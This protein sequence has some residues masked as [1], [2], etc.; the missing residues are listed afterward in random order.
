[1]QVKRL[2]AFFL[3]FVLTAAM[4]MQIPADAFGTVIDFPDVED[5]IW[6][7]KYL[8][9]LTYCEIINGKDDGL[10]HP[11]DT[12]TRGEFMKMIT[13]ATEGLPMTDFSENVHWSQPYWTVLKESNILEISESSQRP[14]G[15]I[16]QRAEQLIPLDWTDLNKPVSRYEMAF[17]INNLVYLVG[18][19]NKMTLADSNDGFANHIAD[20]DTMTMTYRA[21]VEQVYCKGILVGYPDT[22][23]HGNNNLTRAEATAVIYRYLIQ[24]DRE[25]Q[26]FAVEQEPEVIEDP[27]FVSFAFQYRG[28]STAERRKALF[29]DANKSYFTSANDAQGYMVSIKVPVWKISSSGEKYGSTAWITVNR[30]V[31]REVRAIFNDIYNSPERFPIKAVGG[32]RYSDTL[33]HSWGCAIDI[34]PV[35]NYYVSYRT[36]QQVGTCCYK[37]ASQFQNIDSRYCITPNG[38]VVK[39]FAKYGWGWGGQ[40][41]TSGVDYMHFSILASGG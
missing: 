12:V 33:R 38:S 30:L 23:F 40:G 18:R 19:E 26:S 2:T 29:G 11:D 13:C 16:V 31:E 25:V 3:S 7:E 14:D 22:S 20:Y 34:N 36:G 37:N 27:S 35:E 41:W 15:T 6:Y 10:F 8:D 28:M 9:M 4:F 17:I 1:M 39:A 24:K 32:A 5:G 21:A